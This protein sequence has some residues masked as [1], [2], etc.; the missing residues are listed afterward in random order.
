MIDFYPFQAEDSI[1]QILAM[2]WERLIP[3]HPGADER[4]SNV[5]LQ[6]ED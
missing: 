3:G 4:K 1:K 5:H 2:D 6:A